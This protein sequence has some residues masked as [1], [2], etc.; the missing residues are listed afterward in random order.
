MLLL[1]LSLDSFFLCYFLPG[2]GVEAG[3]GDFTGV[4][5][6]VEVA[7]LAGAAAAVLAA[8]GVV[9]AAAGVQEAGRM[10]RNNNS[11]GPVQ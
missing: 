10:K 2:A 7:V 3:Q 9:L 1:A 5:V 11:L 6:L 4:A 8:A